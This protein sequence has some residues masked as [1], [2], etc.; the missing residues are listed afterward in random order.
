ML[1][2]V[3]PVFVYFGNILIEEYLSDLLELEGGGYL[4]KE[5][6]EGSFWWVV[7]M[8]IQVVVL[9]VLSFIVLYT[10]RKN[11]LTCIDKVMYR[12]VFWIIYVSTIF[13]FLNIENN[14]I[15]WDGWMLLKF[16]WYIC[17][18]NMCLIDLHIPVYQWQ[19]VLFCFYS[20]HFG[21]LPIFI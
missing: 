11:I 16:P 14:D 17:W 2:C 13:Y 19:I 10:L 21:F 15:F 6:Q 20:L 18:V 5:A 9:Y 4:M 1:V 12:F 3:I 7:I 8:Y